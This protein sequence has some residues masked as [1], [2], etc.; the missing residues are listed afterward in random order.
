VTSTLS[1]ERIEL[2]HGLV[3]Q[4]FSIDYKNDFV[5][6]AIPSQSGFALKEVK[7]LPEPWCAKCKRYVRV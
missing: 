2:G 6:L 1:F 4:I 3:I 5:R 7:V